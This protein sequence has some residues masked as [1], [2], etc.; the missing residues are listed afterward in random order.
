MSERYSC[1][2]V[3]SLED[4]EGEEVF[5]DQLCLVCGHP[6]CPCCNGWC[7]VLGKLTEKVV[8]GKTYE[9]VEDD[10]ND[11]DGT[12][13]QPCDRCGRLASEHTGSFQ[14]KCPDGGG[15]YENDTGLCCDGKCTYAAEP[16]LTKKDGTPWD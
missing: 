5:S 12:K 15:R 11:P 1:G 9:V 10:P 16:V 2:G 3:S 13:E 7:D 4:P 8:D 14:S 6:P